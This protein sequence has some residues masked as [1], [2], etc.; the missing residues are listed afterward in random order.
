VAADPT[1]DAADCGI[2]V[3]SAVLVQDDTGWQ[4]LAGVGRESRYRAT[5]IGTEWCRKTFADLT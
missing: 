4:Q 1:G 5:K 3:C 2:D